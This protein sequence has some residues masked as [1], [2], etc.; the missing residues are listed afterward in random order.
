MSEL[1]VETKKTDRQSFWDLARFAIIAVLIVVPVRIFLAQPFI[2][3]G[4]SMVPTFQDGQYL[5]I[6]E[7]SYRIGDPQRNDVVIFRYPIDPSKFFIKRVIGLPGETL[8]IQGQKVTIKNEQHPNGLV[9]DESY[10]KN[11]MDS[12]VHITLGS[13]QYFMMGDNRIG[14]SDS[15]YWGPV[16]RSLIVGRALLRLLPINKMG[17]LPGAFKQEE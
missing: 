6:D 7:L 9:L 8:D 2:V 12:E 15:R 5:I 14:S 11:Q 3:S 1:Q 10:V 4:T 17:V 16:K 13:D